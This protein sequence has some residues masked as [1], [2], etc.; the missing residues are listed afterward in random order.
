[1]YI[2]DLTVLYATPD[3]LTA[4]DRFGAALFA[5]FS[6]F[7]GEGGTKRIRLWR[8]F[9]LSLSLSIFARLTTKIRIES[10]DSDRETVQ[11]DQFAS[12]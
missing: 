2:F 4:K 1:M 12:T 9:W 5:A 6:V 7:G 10:A 3:A 8:R 11:R